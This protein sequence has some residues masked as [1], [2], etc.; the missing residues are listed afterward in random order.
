MKLEDNLGLNQVKIEQFGFIYHNIEKQ[1]KILE[2][3]F[4]MPKFVM[5]PPSEV[6][7][8]YRGNLNTFKIKIGLSR[9]FNTQIEL[10]Q[11]VEGESVHKEFLDQ[12]REGLHHLSI[13]VDDMDLFIKKMKELG[14]TKAQEGRVGN[15]I[16]YA[17]FNTEDTLGFILEVH[18]IMKR[19]GKARTSLKSEKN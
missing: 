17:F 10:I 19:R 9:C 11:L 7:C 6:E 12:G 18:E 14:I 2:K 4:G 13:N 15:K 8:E 1:A 3:L 5:I 16:R